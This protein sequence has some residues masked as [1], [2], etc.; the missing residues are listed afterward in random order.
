MPNCFPINASKLHQINNVVVPVGDN[1]VL[2][3]LRGVEHHLSILNYS[4]GDRS[5]IS[6]GKDSLNIN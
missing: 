5:I 2:K 3:S 1:L 6:S 4:K